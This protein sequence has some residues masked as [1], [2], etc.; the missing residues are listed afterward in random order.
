[1]QQR[2]FLFCVLHRVSPLLPHFLRHYAGL[3]FTDLVLAVHEDAGKLDVQGHPESHPPTLHLERC[4]PGIQTGAR[5]ALLCNGLRALYIQRLEWHAVADLDEFHEWPGTLQRITENCG[6][7][8]CLIGEFVD[9]LAPD[10]SLQPILPEP[11]ISIQFP[12]KTRVTKRISRLRSRKIM[13]CRGIVPCWQGTTTWRTS[14]PCLWKEWSTTTSGA[15]VIEQLTA[16][17]D[18]RQA[19]EPT[20]MAMVDRLLSDLSGEDSVLSCRIA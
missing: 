12:L 3:G 10:G 16:R 19:T 7:A 15:G 1:M 14:G 2:W 4:Y 8:N 20:H 5:D 18:A 6:D 13:L 11:D 17:R 9:R